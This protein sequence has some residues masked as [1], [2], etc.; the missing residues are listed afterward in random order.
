MVSGVLFDS[1]KFESFRKSGER[2]ARGRQKGQDIVGLH[3][4]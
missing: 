3:L 2:R 4:V 1:R